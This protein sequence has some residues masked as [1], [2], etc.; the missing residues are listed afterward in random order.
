MIPFTSRTRFTPQ[1]WRKM[2][3]GK[4]AWLNPMAITL[5]RSQIDNFR[6]QNQGPFLE[7]VKRVLSEI[8]A[9]SFLGIATS[10]RNGG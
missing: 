6:R 4:N 8:T 3:A 2:M 9:D 1:A 5:I 7:K 10:Y